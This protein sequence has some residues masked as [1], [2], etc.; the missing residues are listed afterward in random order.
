V[1]DGFE[2]AQVLPSM[3]KVMQAAGRGIRSKN[4]K[5]AIIL[6]DS[7]YDTQVFRKYLPDDVITVEN[8][9]VDTLQ[10]KGFA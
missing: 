9:L 2:Y 6:M 8:N 1:G 4:D 3:I 10:K 7:R 5:C